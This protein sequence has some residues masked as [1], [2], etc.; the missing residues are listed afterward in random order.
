M[1]YNIIQYNLVKLRTRKTEQ[2]TK[3]NQLLFMFLNFQLSPSE[4]Q[5]PFA[6]IRNISANILTSFP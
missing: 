6:T 4:H 1:W 3:N 2:F 5:A